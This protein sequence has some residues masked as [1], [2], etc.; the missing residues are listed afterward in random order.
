MANSITVGTMI[1]SS[2]AQ[3]SPGAKQTVEF[4]L[5]IET[6]TTASARFEAAIATTPLPANTVEEL[7]GDIHTIRAQLQKPSPSRLII[8]EAGKSLRHVVEGIAGG[9]LTPTVATTATALW[10]ALGLG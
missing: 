2:I 5:N 7:K 10:S 6:A 3:A 9:M 8:Q 4:T 1:G